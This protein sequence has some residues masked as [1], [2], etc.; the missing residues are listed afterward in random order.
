MINARTQTLGKRKPHTLGV[1]A[2]PL[3]QEREQLVLHQLEDSTPV[4]VDVQLSP[5]TVFTLSLVFKTDM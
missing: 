3:T 5:C 1:L 4:A 2:S